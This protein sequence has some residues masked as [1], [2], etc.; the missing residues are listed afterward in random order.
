MAL[1]DNIGLFARYSWNDDLSESYGYT[2]ANQSINAGLL[3]NMSFIYR[4]ND[5]LGICGSYGTI[6]TNHQKF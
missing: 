3:L 1:T 2:E 5:R 4:Q 6:S